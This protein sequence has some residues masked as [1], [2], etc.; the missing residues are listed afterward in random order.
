[1]GLTHVSFLL[2]GRLSELHFLSCLLNMLKEKSTSYIF[3]FCVMRAVQT[4]STSC[5]CINQN[6][7]CFPWDGVIAAEVS[8]AFVFTLS[9]MS[10]RFLSACLQQKD[11]KYV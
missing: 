2:T 1:M 7:Q 5:P 6:N 8:Q 10:G 3:F 4:D 11:C 9:A